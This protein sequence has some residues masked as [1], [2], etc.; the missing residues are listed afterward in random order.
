MR[1][2]WIG[3][4]G[5]LSTIIE[6]DTVTEQLD[7][8]VLLAGV[9]QPTEVVIINNSTI[10]SLTP[11]EPAVLFQAQHVDTTIKLINNGTIIGRGGYGG[12][13]A[14][15]YCNSSGCGAGFSGGI[16]GDAIETFHPVVEIENN[17][18]IGGGG[19]G[20][21]Q[22]GGSTDGAGTYGDDGFAGGG[23]GSGA[24][25]GSRSGAPGGVAYLCTNSNFNGTSGGTG[26]PSGGGAGGLGCGGGAD[27]GNG[28]TSSVAATNGQSAF[29]CGGGGG[30][31]WLGAEGG[32]GGLPSIASGYICK[33]TYVAPALAGGKAV[34]TNGNTIIWLAT[35]T[36][37][38]S[39]A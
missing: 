31:G 13:G 17:G 8:D 21:N 32:R 35:G 30:G 4:A 11:T 34:E 29:L 27:G 20:G 12:T 7:L 33:T 16:G 22:G 26:T 25:Y 24:G 9:T 19:G 15:V 5:S 36:R 14:N 18:M 28:G 1:M 37:Y 39:F 3:A 10:G 6:I 38:G 23:G 2:G